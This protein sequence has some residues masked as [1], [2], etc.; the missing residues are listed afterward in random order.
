[1]AD[2]STPSLDYRAMEPY[3]EKV[4]AILGGTKA[5]R[6]STAYLP[7]F[8]NESQKDYDFR[9][10]NAKFTN[11]WRDIVENL[12][13]KPFS[14]E[15]TIEEGAPENINQFIENVDG[16]GNHFHVFGGKVFFYGMAYG[17][18]WVF[19]DHPKR[20][21]GIVSIAD[22]RQANLKP[23][24]VSLKAQDVLAVEVEKVGSDYVI[25]HC[26]FRANTTVRD[27]FEQKTIERIREYNRQDGVVSY[28]VWEKIKNIWT[29]TEDAGTISLD[30]IPLVPF[31]SGREGNGSFTVDPMLSDAADLQIELFQQESGLKYA[32]EATAFPMLAG[33][34]VQ[35][36]VGEDGKVAPVPVGPKSVLYAPPNSEGEHGEWAFIEPNASSLTFLAAD[37]KETITQ[38]RELGRQPLTAQTGNLT[39]VTTAFAAQKGNSAI[40]AAAILFKDAMENCLRITSKW[41]GD[42]QEVGVV[43]Y[44]DFDLGLSDDDATTTL[45]TA[46]TAGDLSQ[47]TYW[48]E[49]KR[50]SI[51]GPSFD[52]D[53][54]EQALLEEGPDDDDNE[55][56]QR[57]LPPQL[58][59]V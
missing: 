37:I 11:V 30:E 50:R 2:V 20:P 51:L 36:S 38:L 31:I 14:E 56:I 5:M 53:E 54:E 10:Q 22:E 26:R 29:K 17:L 8:P 47:R 57:S 19:I 40:M 58:R 12:S 49:L 23:Y 28:Q 42:E 52:P 24:W 27:G 45:S 6:S 32:K 33:N 21:D 44:D 59:A 15:L 39:V 4:S 55:E 41:M 25:S 3:W 9:R 48:A 18:H 1:M 7:K 46:R 13:A 43:V 16:Q 35:P 34:G